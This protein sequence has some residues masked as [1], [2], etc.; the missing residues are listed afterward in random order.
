MIQLMTLILLFLAITVEVIVLSH[1][2]VILKFIIHL[3]FF[4]LRFNV[5]LSFTS[6]HYSEIRIVILILDFYRYSNLIVI[7]TTRIPQLIFK[8]FIFA[9]AYFQHLKLDLPQGLVVTLEKYFLVKAHCSLLQ[10]FINT[11]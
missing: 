7:L 10:Q 4:G 6:I 5:S 3:P 9:I 2:Y 1:N 11:N 8:V